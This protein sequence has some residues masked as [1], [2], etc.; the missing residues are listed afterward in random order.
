MELALCLRV[1]STDTR[2]KL[3]EPWSSPA[4]S[5]AWSVSIL[6]DILMVFMKEFFQ[7]VNFEKNSR[8]QKAWKIT[9]YAM[10]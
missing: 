10:S 4:N 5:W 1:L 7:K 6:F 9:Q 2:G 3:F 8:P